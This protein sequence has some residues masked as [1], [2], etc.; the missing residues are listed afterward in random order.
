MSTSGMHI[1]DALNE[2]L[3]LLAQG[4]TIEECLAR[5]SALADELAPLL[6]LAARTQ[7]AVEAVA[8]SPEAQRAGLGRITDAW[9]AMEERRLRR[10]RGPWRLLRRSWVLAAAAALILAFGG[11][12]TAAAARDS[13]PGEVLYPV[14]QTQERVLLLV[15]FSDSRK[16]DLHA[17][18]A[19]ARAEE[20]A[21]LASR[22]GDIDTLN[23]TAER[24]EVHTRSAV[25]L[26]GG[27]LSG[28]AVVSTEIVRVVG[29]G[30]KEYSLS[31]DVKVQGEISVHGRQFWTDPET[32]RRR[33]WH[34]EASKRRFLMQKRFRDQFTHMRELREGLPLELHPEHRRHFSASFERAEVLLQEA[35]LLMRALE[36]AHHPPE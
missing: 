29:P 5:Y 18:F 13:V 31:R 6:H 34:D 33:P 8:P 23:R 2:C 27:E 36:D 26:M 12:T 1:Q 7:S 14:K 16:A 25:S 11:W 9:T 10:Q 3:E 28:P 4:R 21:K 19:E 32:G 22:G 17:S 15:V 20:C 24:I 30:G 35:F